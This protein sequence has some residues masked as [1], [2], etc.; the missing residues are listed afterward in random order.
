[1]TISINT[2][3]AQVTRFPLFKLDSDVQTAMQR[4]STGSKINATTDNVLALSSQ[5]RLI[6][7]IKG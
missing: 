2:T 3:A 5:Y 7:E 1:M 4:L 6:S